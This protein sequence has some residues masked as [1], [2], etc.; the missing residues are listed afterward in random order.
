MKQIIS[1]ILLLGI[2][3]AKVGNNKEYN[4][5]NHPLIRLAESKGLKAVPLK[6]MIKLR[7]L[8]K[9][10]EKS[11]GKDQ[12][13]K[14]YENDWKRDYKSAMIFSSWTSTYSILVFMTLVYYYIGMIYATEPGDPEYD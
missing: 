1:L 9:E 11:G 12:I 8:I 3:F 6:D 7:K 13:V 2:I 10:C 5:C 14:L 4:P